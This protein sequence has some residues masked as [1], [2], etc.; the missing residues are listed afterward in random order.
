MR[1]PTLPEVLLLAAT[2]TV[3]ACGDDATTPTS[4]AT[5]AQTTETFTGTLQ[6]NAGLTFPFVVTTA[7]AVV[8]TVKQM[9]PM[10][11]YDLAAGGT[12]DF[13]VGETVYQG[14]SL[15]TAN[16]SA[17]VSAWNP[18]TAVLYVNNNAGTLSVPGALIG[19][20]SGATWTLNTVDTPTFSIA[21]GTWSGTVCSVLLAN[22]NAATGGEIDGVAQGQG[23]LCVRVAD[24]GH[25]AI[26]TTFTLNVTH[27]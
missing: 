14:A 11:N 9:S 7:G 20:T 3:A 19:A 21:L 26:P 24:N 4:P 23:S 25:I 10:F 8:A 16:A 17:T 6:L 15:D 12:G 1:R 22:D 13:V 18:A 2:L 27:Y 5:P